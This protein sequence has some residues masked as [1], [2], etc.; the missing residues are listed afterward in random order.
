MSNKGK[1]IDASPLP[2]ASQTGRSPDFRSRVSPKLG[3]IFDW[4]G[5]IIDSSKH[6]E[7]SWERLAADEM[8]PLPKDHFKA[9]F[10]KKTEWIIEHQ[11]GFA[12]NDSDVRR[13]S[14]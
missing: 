4:D 6:H 14:L 12:H 8:R 5:V 11:L 3:V 2:A 7:E 13:L 9:G 1:A 10:G